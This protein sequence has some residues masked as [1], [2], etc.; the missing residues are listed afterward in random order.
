MSSRILPGYSRGIEQYTWRAFLPDIHG[1]PSAEQTSSIDTQLSALAAEA[2][3]K[4]EEAFER[5]RR[6]GRLEGERAALAQLDPVI[7]R[8]SRAIA[9][10][11]SSGAAL[12]REAEEDVVKLAV[13]IARRILNREL[14]LDP[15]AVLGLV[16]VALERVDANEVHRVRVHPEDAPRIAAELEAMSL[17]EKIGVVA[18]STLERG[19]VLL[20]TRRGTL[21]ASL[22]TQLA[23]I[24]RGL[25]DRVRRRP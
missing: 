12:R 5:G 10:V 21:D 17:A 3:R 20:E 22:S 19:A 1:R 16:R 23:E 8:L 11:A 15:E 7:S 2:E 24:E 18:D 6:E 4:M 13:A 25:T 14:S 9:E